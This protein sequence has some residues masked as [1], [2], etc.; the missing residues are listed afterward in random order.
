[1][2]FSVQFVKPEDYP[3]D[4][5]S[6]VGG[7]IDGGTTLFSGA[8]SELFAPS[9]SG[10][11]GTA[12]VTRYMKVWIK[13]DGDDIS[14]LTVFL[15]NVEYPEQLSI[16]FANGNDTAANVLSMPSGLSGPDFS[17]PIGLANGIQPTSTSLTNGSSVAIWVKLTLP[18]GL[19]ADSAATAVLSVAG[20]V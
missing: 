12:A 13:N 7:A 14:D 19:T 18:S 10:F 2:A 15:Q 1:M 16:A 4:D 5:T 17:T 3:S 6:Q 11:V 9:T 8:L 20:T